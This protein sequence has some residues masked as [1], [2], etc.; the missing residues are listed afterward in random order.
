MDFV[1][2]C[3]YELALGAAHV[4][5]SCFTLLRPPIYK[6]LLNLNLVT[7]EKGH[8]V[9]PRSWLNLARSYPCLR[10]ENVQVSQIS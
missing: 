6:I 3:G 5:V 4:E 10:Y 8:H 1:K 9:L 7:C 2:G